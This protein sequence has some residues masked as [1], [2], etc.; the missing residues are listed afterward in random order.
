MLCKPAGK[1][2]LELRAEI[3]YLYSK[4]VHPTSRCPHRG[5]SG[6]GLVSPMVSHE[7]SHQTNQSCRALS[8][9]DFG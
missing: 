5:K 4:E 1:T 7:R 6:F 9:Q 2:R 8:W 3:D